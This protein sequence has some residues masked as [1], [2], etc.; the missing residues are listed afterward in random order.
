MVTTKRLAIIA[1]LWITAAGY[2]ADR[3]VSTSSAGCDTDN[4]LTL[5]ASFASRPDI[6]TDQDSVVSLRRPAH[7]A[8]ED[9]FPATGTC[10]D[11]DGGNVPSVAS[12]AVDGSGIGYYLDSCSGS[13]NTLYE[14]V[15]NGYYVTSISHTCTCVHVTIQIPGWGSAASARC[16]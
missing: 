4:Y 1:T 6:R 15:C 5:L 7:E 3:P 13:G 11:K 2:G 14:K 10:S 12:Y 16:N 8:G 9:S